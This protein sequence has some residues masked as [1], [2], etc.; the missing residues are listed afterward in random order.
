MTVVPVKTTIPGEALGVNGVASLAQDVVASIRIKRI[1]RESTRSTHTAYFSESSS[2]RDA[3]VEE[4][5]TCEI[6]GLVGAHSQC[7]VLCE[8]GT[9]KSETLWCAACED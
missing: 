9:F 3:L 2:S 4:D 8:A 6:N 1:Q 7:S 5:S